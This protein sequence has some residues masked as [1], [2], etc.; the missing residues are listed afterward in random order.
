MSNSDTPVTTGTRPFTTS[1]ALQDR[2][3]LFRIKRI[4][5]A[6]GAHDDQAVDAVIDEGVKHALR[7]VDVDREIFM[8]IES[9]RRGKT[10]C[11]PVVMGSSC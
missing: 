5:L 8:G 10:P 7:G 9:L 3:L 4:V 2:A 6:A 1:T 11:Q